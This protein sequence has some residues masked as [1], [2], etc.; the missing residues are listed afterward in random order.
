M[1]QDG[2][3][4]ATWGLKNFAPREVRDSEHDLERSVS[5]KLRAMP[6]LWLSI[7]DEAGP[8]SLRGYIERN[9][10][11]LLSNYAKQQLL[12]PPSCNWLG[13]CCDRE[14]VRNSGLWNSNHVDETYDPA[15][16]VRLDNLVREMEVAE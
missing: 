5:R 13:H 6:F 10:I 8:Q 1:E 14:R 9:A 3:E 7:E 16:L 12:D 15:F 2:Y 11:A 4:C